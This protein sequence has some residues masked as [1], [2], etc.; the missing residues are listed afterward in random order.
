M[1]PIFSIYVK[2]TTNTFL[3]YLFD[4]GNDDDLCT[5][6]SDSEDDFNYVDDDNDNEDFVFTFGDT[7]AKAL[8]LWTVKFGISYMDLSALLIILRRFGLIELPKLAR[9]LLRTPRKAVQP[10]SCPPGKIFY[11]G[12]QY[13]ST[14]TTTNF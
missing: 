3:V 6:F 2:N 9:T 11:R 1:D 4:V 5:S 13:Y 10:K 7:I 8:I 12:I 14:S